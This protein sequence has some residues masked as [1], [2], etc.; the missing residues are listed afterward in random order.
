MVAEQRDFTVKAEDN[1]SDEIADIAW[2]FNAV[3]IDVR[4]L[5]SQVQGSIHELGYVSS[6]LQ[7]DGMDVERAKQNSNNKP[8][9]LRLGDKP[10]G[11]QHPKCYRTNSENASSNA[12]T[13]FS[14]ANDGLNDVAFTRTPSIILRLTPSSVLV[15]K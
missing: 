10:N 11:Q 1:S 2:S 3:L 14:T 4:Q 6:Q 5:V 9:T 13:S 7:Q 15:K 12:Q 8:K